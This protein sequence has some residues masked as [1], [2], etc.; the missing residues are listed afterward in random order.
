[1]NVSPARLLILEDE[2]EFYPL[3]ARI[4]ERAGY[5][6]TFEGDGEAGLEAASSGN[7]DLCL[8]NVMLRGLDGY[9]IVHQLQ[10]R[11]IEIPLIFLTGK[12][13]KDVEAKTANLHLKI[14]Y[15]QKPFSQVG[16]IQ[17]VAEVLDGKGWL[18]RED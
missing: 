15:V 14:A 9:S 1:M 8:L 5:T 11:E 6:V 17:K 16:L 7:F 10:E 18:Q 2:E 12:S 13:R 4:L 3:Y